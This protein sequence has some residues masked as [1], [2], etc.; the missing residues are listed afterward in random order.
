[1]TSIPK[2]LIDIIQQIIANKDKEKLEEQEQM[3]QLE[4]PVYI[5]EK[6][7]KESNIIHIQL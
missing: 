1:M 4:L 7:E 6:Q 2:D 5:E 3:E